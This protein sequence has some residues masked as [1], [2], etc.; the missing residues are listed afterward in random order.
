[1]NRS[2]SRPFPAAFG[3]LTAA[4]LFAAASVFAQSAPAGSSP[5]AQQQSQAP[6]AQ[7]GWQ[8]FNGGWGKQAPPNANAAVPQTPQD[9]PPAPGQSPPPAPA[10]GAPPQDSYVPPGTLTVPAGTFVTVRTNQMLSSDHNQQGDIFSATLSQP[11]VVNGYVV[12]QSGQSVYGRVAEA[13]KAG[14]VKGVSELKLELTGLT[15]VDGQNLNTQ[16]VL[17]NRKGPTSNGRDAA[18]VGGTTAL[19]AALGAA[20]GWGTGAAIGAGAGA[21]AGLI[22]VLFTRG[23]PTIVPPE[24]LLTFQTSAPATIDTSHAPAAFQLVQPGDYQQAQNQQVPPSTGYGCGPNG[25]PPPAY[26]YYAGYGPAYYPYYYSPFFFGPAFG[27]F[28]GPGY[29]YRGGYYGYGR[30]YRGYPRAVPHAGGGVRR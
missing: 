3:I 14:M 21:A 27:F 10:A 1:M 15:L 2:S 16:S 5:D 6:P 24:T 17:V 11:V 23:Y 20:A 19:G 7:D 8:K 9:Q 18:A 26:P 12:A 13:K 22:G 29:F 28:Y 4:T 30:Y 25:C